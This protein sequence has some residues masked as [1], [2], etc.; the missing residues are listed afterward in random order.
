MS[1]IPDFLP[2]SILSCWRYHFQN[3]LTVFAVYDSHGILSGQCF[4]SGPMSLPAATDA[5]GFLCI[6]ECRSAQKPDWLTL[7]FVLYSTSV[8]FLQF[9]VVLW[10]PAQYLEVYFI[11]S[12]HQIP[13]LREA[14]LHCCCLLCHLIPSIELFLKTP[15]KHIF[16]PFIP[17]SP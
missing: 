4:W 13:G 2:N 1:T 17:S 15:V 8:A 16:P 12:L 3:H 11:P 5:L 9:P 10:A 7:F 14:I 6:I